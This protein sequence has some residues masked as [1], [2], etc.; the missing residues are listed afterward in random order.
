MQKWAQALHVFLPFPPPPLKWAREPI[1]E[2]ES[3]NKYCTLLICTQSKILIS[4]L[5]RMKWYFWCN[6]SYLLQILPFRRQVCPNT[7]Y[8][9]IWITKRICISYWK[10]DF[11]TS[12]HWAGTNRLPGSFASDNSLKHNSKEMKTSLNSKDLNY[13]QNMLLPLAATKG[14]FPCHCWG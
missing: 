13:P 1:C 8:F 6:S 5:L 12:M 7:I 11:I 3:E 9:P 4:A 2:G 10:S 14:S